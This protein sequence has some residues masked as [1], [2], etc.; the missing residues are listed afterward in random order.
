MINTILS[1]FSKVILFP[2]KVNFIGGLN[3]LH[4]ELFSSNKDYD[5]F[6]Y[7]TLNTELLDC[8]KSLKNKYSINIFTTGEIQN[9]T[10]VKEIIKPIFDQIISANEFALSKTDS[11][12]YV[13]VTKKLL[14]RPEE[15]LYIDDN[16]KN[17]IAAKKAGLNTF[18]YKDNKSLISFLN[19][20]SN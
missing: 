8:Y 6:E 9:V 19:S 12:S 15:I 17:I 13:S 16:E 20:I 14:K 1:D 4:R 18:L 5:F 3:R 2:K 7:F 11:K 10:Q